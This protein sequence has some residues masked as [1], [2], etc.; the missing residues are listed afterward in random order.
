MNKKTCYCFLFVFFLS[1]LAFAQSFRFS[2]RIISAEDRQPISGA[3]IT[4]KGG[5]AGATSQS[6]GSFSILVSPNATLVVT[7]INFTPLELGVDANTPTEISLEPSTRS[8]DQ[9]VVVGYGTVRKRD[10]TGAVSQVKA[11]DLNVFATNTPLQALQGRAAGVQVI[12]N[13]GSPGG[14]ISVRIR[15]TN[16]V[17][18]S[19]E[20]LY[21]V[22]GFPLNGSL[23]LLNN[24]DI[25]SMEILKDAS[26]IAIYGSLEIRHA[27]AIAGK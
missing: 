22:D 11:K 25:E 27:K 15:G 16:S 2:G 26:A 24:A 3:S 4:E 13:S 21:V 14:S 23:S 17:Q 19:N 9:V 10:L 18:G 20:P 8:L 1:Q 7:S 5:T 6:D 12:Q